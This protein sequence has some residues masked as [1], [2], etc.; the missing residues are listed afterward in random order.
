MRFGQN[1][2]K[3]ERIR[4]KRRIQV[5]DHRGMSQNGGN[6]L[7]WNQ[8]APKSSRKCVFLSPNLTTQP[9]RKMS[10]IEVGLTALA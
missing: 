1:S 5:K 8:I 2:Y 10:S 7:G 9:T 6:R 4:T 3:P